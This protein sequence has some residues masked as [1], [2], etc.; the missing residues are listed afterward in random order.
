MKETE[1]GMAAART[2]ADVDLSAIIGNVREIDRLA[3]LDGIVMAVVKADGYGHGAVPIARACLRAGVEHF[4]VATLAEGL[5]LRDAGIPGEIYTLSPF[6]PDEADAIV[7]GD[8]IPMLCSQEQ[9]NALAWTAEHAP[10]PARAFL[11]V[12]TGMGRE[13]CLPDEAR[14]LW[15]E[16]ACLPNV[17]LTGIATHFSSV[18]DPAADPITDAQVAAFR[19]F[20]DSLG[21]DA[22]AMAEDGRGNRGIWLSLCNSPGTLRLP[23]LPLP[24]GARGYLY[25]PGAILYGIEPY[26]N[27]F[28]G[29]DLR[30]ALTW[31]ARIALIRDLPAGFPI[32]YSRTYTL[33][34]ASRIATLSVGYADG[35]P[36][37]LSNCGHVLIRGQ[38]F[39]V[40]G[41]ISMD[42]CQVDVTDAAAPVAVGDLVTLIGTDGAETQT[43]FDIAEMI[44]TTSHEP[45]CS[46]T[47]RV[48]R[49]YIGGEK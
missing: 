33:T 32:G 38:R 30:P 3:G 15:H 44:H 12:D 43:I 10:F 36:R 2:W 19:A 31:K 5:E 46:L 16:A 17:R 40:V 13:G 42:Q 4:A 6:L 14:D 37:R 29:T 49:R 21:P 34:R 35:L 22:L 8:L 39:P 47:K 27:A 28:N 24:K 7:R 11:I 23:P 26:R 48:L 1:R 20:V 45:A 25:R 9:L 18:D 41:R